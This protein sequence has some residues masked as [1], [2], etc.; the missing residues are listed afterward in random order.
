M[1]VVFKSTNTYI[2]D[3]LSLFD[4]LLFGIRFSC[5]KINYDDF[6]QK[7]SKEEELLHGF[8]EG[9]FTLVDFPR[10]MIYYNKKNDWQFHSLNMYFMIKNNFIP[11]KYS[12]LKSELNFLRSNGDLSY[13]YLCSNE[14][15]ILS[16]KINDIWVNCNFNKDNKKI[17]TEYLDTNICGFEL[18][19][20]VPLKTIMKLNKIDSISITLN[21]FSDN[22]INSKDKQVKVFLYF[23]N[24]KLIE[25]VDSIILPFLKKNE[26]NFKLQYNK[27]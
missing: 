1:S 27:I 16:T 14:S 13:G 5:K 25:W 9:V 7:H 24:E 8:I 3:K 19:K 23:M 2:Q 20:T 10:G 21:R 17:N 4:I 11:N 22:Y 12:N 18:R 26:I 15:L 6:E